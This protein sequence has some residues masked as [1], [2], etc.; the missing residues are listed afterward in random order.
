MSRRKCKSGFVKQKNVCVPHYREGS[1]IVYKTHKEGKRRF[2]TVKEKHSDFKN[3]KEGFVGVGT[4][5]KDTAMY[6]GYSD[7]ITSVSKY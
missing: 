1:R 6:W 5:K 2:V 4:R 7:Q 3:K